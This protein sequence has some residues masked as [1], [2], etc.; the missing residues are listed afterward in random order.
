L[1]PEVIVVN[2]SG[3]SQARFDL[4]QNQLT[5]SKNSRLTTGGAR[6]LVAED[7]RDTRWAVEMFFQALGHGQS[8]FLPECV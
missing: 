1:E 7:H 6:I 4:S 3:S 5:E 2:V 8:C